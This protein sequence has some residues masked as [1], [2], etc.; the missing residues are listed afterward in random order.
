MKKRVSLVDREELEEEEEEEEIQEEILLSSPKECLEIPNFG[1]TVIAGMTESGKTN[2]LLHLL[3]YNAELFNKVFLLCPTSSASG[4][5]KCLPKKSI[6]SKEEEVKRLLKE[7][8]TSRNKIAIIL[9]DVIGSV[10]LQS[11]SLFDKIASSGRHYKVHF[12][13]GFKEAVPSN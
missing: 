6:L 12:H 7:Q 10:R 11:S 9:D 8:E 5:Y 4:D 13:S 1:T 2:L 3:R